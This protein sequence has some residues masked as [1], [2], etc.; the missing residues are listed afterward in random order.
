MKIRNGF[1]YGGLK[2]N[3][4]SILTLE[5][6]FFFFCFFFFYFKFFTVSL[7]VFLRVISFSTDRKKKELGLTG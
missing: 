3:N 1:N 5:E 4:S 2:G 7:Y 6:S